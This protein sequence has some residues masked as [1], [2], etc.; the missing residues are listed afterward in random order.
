MEFWAQLITQ[1]G[2]PIVAVLAMGAF[3]WVIYKRSEVREDKL[4]EELSKSQDINA[5]A[6]ETLAV[7]N[8]RLGNIETDVKAIKDNIIQG[9]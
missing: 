7:Y 2:F 1:F 4:A 8:E 5:K 3:I 9:E 6:I